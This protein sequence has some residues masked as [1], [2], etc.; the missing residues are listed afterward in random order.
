MTRASADGFVVWIT[1][2]P[3]AGKTTL[4]AGLVRTLR[5]RNIPVLWLDSDDLRQ[6]MTPNATYSDEERQRFYGTLGHISQRAATGGVPVVVSATASQRSYRD[7]VR[8]RIEQFI[9]VWLTCDED[10]LRHRDPKGLYKSAEGGKIENFPG[11][12]ALFEPPESAEVVLDSAALNQDELLQRL[13]A[14]LESSG[15]L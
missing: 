2:R 8:N 3:A 12:D 1:G 13:L 5:Q 15:M 4:A 7:A 14:F 6:V 11:V 9:E 10:T